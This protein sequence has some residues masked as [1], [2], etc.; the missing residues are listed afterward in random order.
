MSELA[1]YLMQYHFDAI[2]NNDD[3]KSAALEAI[4]TLQKQINKLK[5]DR[6]ML[7]STDRNGVRRCDYCGR[8]LDSEV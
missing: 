2:S 5:L 7:S 1:D 3:V 6:D 4:K 8:I